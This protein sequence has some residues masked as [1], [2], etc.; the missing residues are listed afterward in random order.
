[1]MWLAR[2]GAV[3][4]DPFKS[5]AAKTAPTHNLQIDLSGLEV[6]QLLEL[7]ARVDSL[8][9]VRS[10]K[11]LDLAQELVLQVQALQALQMRVM[12]DETVPVNQV[13]QVANSLSA[14][15]ANLIRVQETTY[16]SER[17]KRLEALMIETLST[18]SAS[19]QSK[20]LKSYEE[21]L[22]G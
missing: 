4:L 8:L 2:G 15:L 10:L 18:L 20:F 11:D 22:G 16:D 1:M 19:A 12:G 17:V 14:A 21:A 3:K 6:D 7:R 9:P 5:A 13:A